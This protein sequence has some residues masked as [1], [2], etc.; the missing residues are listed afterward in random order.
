MTLSFYLPVPLDQ[1]C[2]LTVQLPDDYDISTVEYVG[3]LQV[4]GAYKEYTVADGTLTIDRGDNSF[5]I[6]PCARYINNDN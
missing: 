3:S 1:G 4:F 2:R 5:M 6:K